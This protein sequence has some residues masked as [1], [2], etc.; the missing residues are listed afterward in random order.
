MLDNVDDDLPDELFGKSMIELQNVYGG[1][2]KTRIAL[3][4]YQLEYNI[5][6]ELK[7]LI[8]ANKNIRY[9]ENISDTLSKIE[10]NQGWTFRKTSNSRTRKYLLLGSGQEIKFCK[11]GSKE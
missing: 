1:M 9:P 8:E 3:Y 7:R 6:K 4:Y 10:M 11:T 5:S 2:I